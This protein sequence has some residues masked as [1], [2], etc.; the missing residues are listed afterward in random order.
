[1]LDV[2]L[3]SRLPP[4][5]GKQLVPG[6]QFNKHTMQAGTQS[7]HQCLLGQQHSWQQS[8]EQANFEALELGPEHMHTLCG[9]QHQRHPPQMLQQHQDRPGLCSA[10]HHL[11]KPLAAAAAAPVAALC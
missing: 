7:G 11:W 6:L 8:W 9:R 4:C 2:R 3:C 10:C 1:M 5:G